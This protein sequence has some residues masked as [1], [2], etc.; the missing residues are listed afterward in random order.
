MPVKKKLKL[1]VIGGF[2][3]LHHCMYLYWIRFQIPLLNDVTQK[4]HRVHMEFT[5]LPLHKKPIFQEVMEDLPHVNL[6]F[7]NCL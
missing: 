2:G 3:P 6:M 4:S 1:L 5:F 7:S